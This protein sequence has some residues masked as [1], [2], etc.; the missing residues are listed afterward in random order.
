MSI[1]V[2]GNENVRRLRH[3]DHIEFWKACL[4]WAFWRWEGGRSILLGIAGWGSTTGA[5]VGSI[6]THTWFP[7]IPAILLFSIALT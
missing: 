2:V 7:M 4:K 6:S 1:L 3:H 5:A